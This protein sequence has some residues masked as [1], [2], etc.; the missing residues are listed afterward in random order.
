MDPILITIGNFE[1]KWYSVLILIGMI[2]AYFGIMKETDR[3]KIDKNFIINIIFWTVIFGIIGAR[4][5]Y[6]VFNW[7]FYGHNFSE[8]YKTWNGGLAI[9]GGILL[10]GLTVF[11]YCKK[12]K[13]SAGK[14]LDMFAPFIL[15]AQA[16]GRWGNFF[17]SEAY[18]NFTSY[19]QLKSFKI[20]P[21]FVI[22]GMQINGNYYLPMFYF[23]SLWCII[24][25][26]VLLF[27]RRIKTIKNGQLI[28]LYIMWYSF[29]RF[30]IE[31]Q[32]TDSL[33]LGNLRVAQVV[34]VILFIVAYI[35][36]LVK[37]KKNKKDDLY[38][39]SSGKLMY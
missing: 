25:F 30:F 32:R 16:I 29:G 17:N 8:I 28:C 3:F 6:V 10:G 19:A 22:K 37:A 4:L 31:M 15:F 7:D 20:I 14:V 18:G 13:F 5:Y 24:G 1:V 27:I 12:Y 33:L 9:H 34:S 36:L 35:V 38:N 21:E 26:I 23:E 39:E 2:V 11:I